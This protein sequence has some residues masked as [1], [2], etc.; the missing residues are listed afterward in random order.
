[1]AP[2][3]LTGVETTENSKSYLVLSLMQTALQNHRAEENT[4]KR[5]YTKFRLQHA[6]RKQQGNIL[7]IKQTHTIS[8][9]ELNCPD[10]KDQNTIL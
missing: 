10:E 2:D 5:T 6:T 9:T 1:M 7:K 4:Y 8:Q 3:C